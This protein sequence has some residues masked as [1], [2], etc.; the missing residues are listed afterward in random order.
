MR[1]AFIVIFVAMLVIGGLIVSCNDGSIIDDLFGNLVVSFDANGGTGEMAD[2]KTSRDV[3]TALPAN[4]FT[5]D[6][7]I[8]TGW[9]DKADGSG[10]AYADRAVAGFGEDTVL[11]AQWL[12]EVTI[13]FNANDGSEAPA[14]KTQKLG[15]GVEAALDSNTFSR[16]GY[17]FQGWSSSVIGNIEYADKE[18]VTLIADKVLYAKW[19]LNPQITL[20][21]GTGIDSV[22]GAGSYVPGASAT[23][24]A[25][26][27]SGYK[28]D[29]WTKT[30]D[31]TTAAMS[32]TFALTV[33]RDSLA[34]TANALPISYSVAF[35]ANDEDATGTMEA[36]SFT[37][38]DAQNLSENEFEL[39]DMVFS[40]WNTA[41]DGTGTSYAD[42]QNVNNLSST[43]GATVTLYAQWEEAPAGFTV[44]FHANDGSAEP[45]TKTQIVEVDEETAPDSNTFTR[46]DYMFIYWNTEA[47][48]SGMD[49]EENAVVTLEDNLDLYAIWAY[50][51]SLDPILDWTDG[52]I[53]S[54]STWGLFEMEERINVSGNAALYLSEEALFQANHGI[55]VTDSAVLTIFG[56]GSL[57]AWGGAGQAG[58]GGDNNHG[59]GTIIINGGYIEAHGGTGAAGIGGGDG[60]DGG[61][62]I[63]NDGIVNAYG[64][65][66][67]THG[68]SAGIGG[69][70]RGAAGNISIYGG[71]VNAVGSSRNY[72]AGAGIGNGYEVDWE[73]SGSI[74]IYGGSVYAVAGNMTMSGI[75]TSFEGYNNVTF[76]F[77][78][79]TT[80]YGGNDDG[81]MTKLAEGPK[82][83]Y[84]GTYYQHM[85]V[86]EDGYED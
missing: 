21:K 76:S 65:S 11:F 73:S 35:D 7:F 4:G 12:E 80:L 23:I 22:S 40:G 67:P 47:D 85:L 74:T 56:P 45:A 53:Y 43:D 27:S 41:A 66:D 62:I 15:K 42:G 51:L 86:Q 18:N 2:L 48:G 25:T 50:D 64:T 71:Y 5:R 81:S 44:T 60:H 9:N 20:S 24:D 57:E 28:W 78:E 37:Y 33:G 79:G 16:E 13:T 58:I 46:D 32:K 75:S 29:K 17:Y 6:G 59:T 68:A 61:T 49:Y 31:G 69:G 55:S 1:K 52:N 54:Y 10:K 84:R 63:I 38:G 70:D 30:S 77:G 72:S 83:D 36:Q 34:F 14:T 26:L 19:S 3:Q 39:E 8:F 82:D